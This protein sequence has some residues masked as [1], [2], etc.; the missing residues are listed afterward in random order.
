MGCLDT[1]NHTLFALRRLLRQL[2]QQFDNVVPIPLHGAKSE[3]TNLAAAIKDVGRGQDIGT[4]TLESSAVL[5]QQD[6]EL[7]AK[8]NRRTLATG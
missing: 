7:H 8:T 1:L 6:G 2:H 5:V 4:P 3:V